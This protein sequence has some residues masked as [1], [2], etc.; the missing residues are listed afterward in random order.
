[1]RRVVELDDDTTWPAGFRSIVEQAAAAATED[2][3]FFGSDEAEAMGS[4]AGFRVRAYH[5]TRLTPREVESVR[6]E[7][8]KPLSSLFTDERLAN[9]VADGH[10]SKEEA[11]FYGQTELPSDANRAGIVWSF[12]DRASL[13]VA[14]QIGYLVEYWGGE[15]INM[16][17]DSRS[18]EMER[19]RW[20][21]TPSVVIAALDVSNHYQS[22]HPG[23][24]SAAVRHL[25]TK[26]G[27]TSIASKVSINPEY[28]EAIEHPGGTF[29]NQYVWTP[30]RGFVAIDPG[31]R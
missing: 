14:S 13:A 11:A 30:R 4:L 19:L 27:G 28:I 5:C 21:G 29:W 24:L 31:D 6:F 16:D 18:S 23:V 2:T 17:L 10:L 20:V 1:M 12:T 26:D 15:G 7:G 25:R 22:G 9:A 3:W 8:L